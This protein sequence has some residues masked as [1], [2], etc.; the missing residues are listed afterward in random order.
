MPGYRDKDRFKNEL[1]DKRGE[2][3]QKYERK[4][5]RKGLN[6]NV[7]YIGK[8]RDLLVLLAGS[9]SSGNLSPLAG[10]TLVQN[11]LGV[12]LQKKKIESQLPS[13]S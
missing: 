5:E 6:F 2:G 1:I 7:R 11:E 10:I 3:I 4:G 8:S 12:H 9:A 13:L